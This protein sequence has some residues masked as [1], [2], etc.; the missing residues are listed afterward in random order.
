MTKRQS[1]KSVYVAVLALFLFVA[2]LFG[3]WQALPAFAEETG[4]TNVLVD[5]QKDELFNIADYPENATNYSIQVIQIAESTAGELFVYTYQPSQNT[6]SFTATE[7][8]MSLSE[9]ADG[10]KL[11]SLMLLN[12]SG[13]FG[14]YLVN[15][16]AVS[17]DFIR[18]YNITSIYRPWDKDIDKET[19]NDNTKNAVAYEVGTLFRAKTENNEV[20]YASKKTDIIRIL[21]PYVDYLEYSNGFKFCPDWCH[22]HYVAFSTDKQ[23]DA[24]LEADVSYVSRDASRSTGLGLSGDTTYKN[25]Q[26]ITK[27]VKGTEKGGNAADGFRAK[28]YEWERIQSVSDFISSEDLKDETKKNLEGAQWVLR[29]VETTITVVSGYGSTTRFWTDISNVTVL[30]L[31]FITD[32]KVYNLGAVSDKVTGD[33]E[34]GNNNTNEFAGFWEWLN[35]LTGV[36]KWVWI[37]IIVIL[38]LAILLPILSIF[39]PIVGQILAVVIKAIGKVFVWVFK[40]V[41]WLIC[42]PFKGIAA[43]VRKIKHRKE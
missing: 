7:I 36:P 6:K 5:L 18:Y 25:E 39:F 11:Y 4:Y 28:K 26:S 37:V 23:I 30:R 3:G 41:L 1:A 10:T 42:L 31:K 34:P 12:T 14:K 38:V 22:S 27:T 43:L 29:F 2:A 19:G 15:D 21:N 9:S 40:G 33:D 35:R 13:V 20:L 32:G 8:N 16:I 17:N 24:L